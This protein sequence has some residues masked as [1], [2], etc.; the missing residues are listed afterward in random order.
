MPWFVLSL[1]VVLGVTIESRPP[2]LAAVHSLIEH[3]VTILS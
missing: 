3:V 1:I 2:V